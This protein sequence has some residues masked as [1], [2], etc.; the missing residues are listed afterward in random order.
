[1]PRWLVARMYHFW[2]LPLLFSLALTGCGQRE[3]PLISAHG[4]PGYQFLFVARDEALLTPGGVLS[5]SRNSS[6]S[7]Q[8]LREDRAHAAGLAVD[9]VLPLRDEGIDLRGVLVFNV[10]DG[11]LMLQK[12]LSFSS[13]GDDDVIRGYIELAEQRRAFVE[14]GVAAHFKILA[15]LRSNPIDTSDQRARHMGVDGQAAMSS[16]RRIALPDLYR[17]SELLR[18]TSLPSVT[19]EL[20]QQLMQSGDIKTA[21]DTQHLFSADYLPEPR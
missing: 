20:M 3:P 4:R 10:S 2:L 14:R 19:A 15:N 17:H 21:G 12:F 6:E 18:G 1:M 13:L 5:A 7:M 8:R 11:A 16:L 9:E